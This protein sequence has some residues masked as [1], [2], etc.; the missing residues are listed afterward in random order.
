MPDLPILCAGAVLLWGVTRIF[1]SPLRVAI[2]GLVH[3]QAG[4][5]AARLGLRSGMTTA[6]LNYSE[7]L[8]RARREAG[9]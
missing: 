6:R 2:K 8:A 3:L 9:Q 5:W 7:C 1:C 4:F